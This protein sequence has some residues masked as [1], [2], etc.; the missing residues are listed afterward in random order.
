LKAAFRLRNEQTRAF[1]ES[2]DMKTP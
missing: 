2:P 1:R